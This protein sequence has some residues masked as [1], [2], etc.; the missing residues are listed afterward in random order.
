MTRA[1]A[2]ETVDYIVT[3][4]EMT[5]RP[6]NGWPSQPL[7]APAT[8]LVAE[9][10][11]AWYF[12]SLYSAV[13]HPHHWIDQIERP[14]DELES[15]LAAPEVRLYTLMRQ[16]WPNGMFVLDAQEPGQ[17]NL[18]YFGLV[19][20][21]LGQGLGSFLLRTAILSAWDM[22]G[23]TRLTV[24]TCTLDHPRALS[25]YQKQGFSPVR[26]ER[27]QIVLRHDIDLQR[28]HD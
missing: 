3:F 15:W 8:L 16:G 23:M 1:R 20:E 25:L 11:P 17:C 19:P 2:G 26:Q 28:L 24:N 4:L 27:R 21:A 12:L 6:A 18:A 10:P 9:A 7:G 5:E 13:G 22:P 14:R